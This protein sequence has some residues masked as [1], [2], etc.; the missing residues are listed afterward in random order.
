MAGVVAAMA[1][2][3]RLYAYLACQLARAYPFADHEY[4]GGRAGGPGGLQLA[5]G[6]AGA[7]R[8]WCGG[9]VGGGAWAGDAP[10]AAR[11][12]SPRPTP[13]LPRHEP[14][15]SRHPAPPHPTPPSSSPC[16][17]RLPR[18]TEWVRSYSSPEYLRLPAR[19]EAV[20]D[21]AA[22]AEPYGA[23]TPRVVSWGLGSGGG[24]GRGRRG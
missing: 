18:T 20:L 3:L 22:D 2:C 5:A 11:V 6:R 9:W 8:P 10:R 16:P 17:P 12:P 21:E 13:T 4:T 15:S 19:A 7:H 23:P 24:R 14:P 1:P